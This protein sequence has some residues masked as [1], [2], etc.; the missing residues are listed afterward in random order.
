MPGVERNA[1]GNIVTYEAALKA[2]SPGVLIQQSRNGDGQRCLSATATGLVPMALQGRTHS[3]NH[4]VNIDIDLPFAPA[5]HV[6][7]LAIRGAELRGLA[8]WG[9]RRIGWS[10]VDY[11]SRPQD[12]GIRANVTL[13]VN[14][15]EAWSLGV[16]YQCT[17]ISAPREGDEATEA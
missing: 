7:S 3:T 13:W 11:S 8:R 5:E 2:P 16:I 10:I 1:E 15:A 9:F 17:A 12:A 14:N 4:N 6:L